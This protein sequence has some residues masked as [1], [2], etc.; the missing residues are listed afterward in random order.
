MRFCLK[1]FQIGNTLGI[2]L[3]AVIYLFVLNK[4]K[5]ER[6]AG[7]FLFKWPVP[8][9]WIWRY[10]LS[11]KNRTKHCLQAVEIEPWASVPTMLC[12]S[13]A[14]AGWQSLLRW[15]TSPG[16][17]RGTWWKSSTWW[18]RLLTSPKP[19][20][21]R[22][23]FL[24]LLNRK[25]R[26]HRVCCQAMLNRSWPLRRSM[27]PMDGCVALAKFLFVVLDDLTVN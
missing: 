4:F 12:S 14:V 9:I 10:L 21:F 23:F 8:N 2:L 7:R 6:D 17:Q 5:F 24:F 3:V 26:N 27:P 13:R 19:L 11:I 15:Q 25:P 22:F 20:L 16:Q 18:Q 1:Q